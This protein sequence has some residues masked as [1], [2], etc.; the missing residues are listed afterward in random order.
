LHHIPAATRAKSTK[1]TAGEAIGVTKTTRRR[2]GQ[3]RGGN[4]HSL[5]R[6]EEGVNNKPNAL[7]SS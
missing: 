3:E 2:R 5:K 1:K 6:E 4:K 7:I